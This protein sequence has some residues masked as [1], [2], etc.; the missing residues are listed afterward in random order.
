MNKE[1]QKKFYEW[2]EQFIVEKGYETY[3]NPTDGG[4]YRIVTID[5]IVLYQETHEWNEWLNGKLEEY[6]KI[7][8]LK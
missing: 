1:Q 3:Y 6:N 5:G 8:E 2:L 4:D 7:E